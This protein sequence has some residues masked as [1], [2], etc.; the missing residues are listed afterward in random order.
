MVDNGLLA[1]RLKWARREQGVTLQQL[2]ERC[3]RAVSYLSQLEHGVKDNPTRQTVEA[4][5]MALGVRPAF[6]FGEVSGP[7]SDRA[8]AAQPG[9]GLTGM[10]RQFRAYVA[11]LPAGERAELEQGEPARRFQALARFLLERFP[12]SFTA[13]ELAFQLGI[14]FAYYREIMEY[15]AEVSLYIAEQM[16]RISGVPVPFLT[17]GS[18]EAAPA[19]ALNADA[20]RYLEAIRLALEHNLTPEQLEQ[21]ILTAAAR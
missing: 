10:A 4:L 13:V 14:S 19:P 2:S 11:G 1:Q 8:P 12:D 21:M 7:V 6:L 18:F 16:A 5:A 17:H 20:L 9:S 3:S 15:N